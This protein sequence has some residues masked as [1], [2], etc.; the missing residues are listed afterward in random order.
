MAFSSLSRFPFLRTCRSFPASQLRRCANL[1][2]FWASPFLIRVR[3]Y[4]FT[5]YTPETLLNHVLRTFGSRRS[6]TGEFLKSLINFSWN[7]LSLC[8]NKC[9]WLRD[10]K[11]RLICKNKPSGGKEWS[12][13]AK[14]EFSFALIFALL[15]V[16][17]YCVGINHQKGGDWKGNVPL[18]HFQV[19]WWL[20]VQHKCL[21]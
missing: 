11:L 17:F 14:F 19:F 10:R 12:K 2:I 9:V 20:S 16:A 15:L 6:P 18:G 1:R 3:R 13:Y 4:L 21:S 7:K 5:H 8:L